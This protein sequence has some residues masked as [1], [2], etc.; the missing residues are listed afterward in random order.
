MAK[1]YIGEVLN[2]HIEAPNMIHL[3]NKKF[4]ESANQ[5]YYHFLL[6]RLVVVVEHMVSSTPARL[7]KF[8]KQIQIKA[9][10]TKW[11]PSGLNFF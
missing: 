2:D 8:A 6:V 5:L 4:G 3:V 9:R 11:P 10:P 1:V 7:I